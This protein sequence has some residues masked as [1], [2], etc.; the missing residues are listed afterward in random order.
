MRRR[1][2][3]GDLEAPVCEVEDLSPDGSL[4]LGL[5][6]GG[7]ATGADFRGM[8]DN[9]IRMCDLSERRPC[10]SKLPASFPPGLLAE[11]AGALHLLPRWI[12]RW[13]QA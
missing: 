4:W 13:G 6:E 8:T 3:F 12:K 9:L 1:A 5:M 11:A 2:M 7:A 10:V